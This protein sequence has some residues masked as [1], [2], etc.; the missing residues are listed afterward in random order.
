MDNKTSPQSEKLDST[1]DD[2]QKHENIS[3][4]NQPDE[5]K[6]KRD[7]RKIIVVTM[8]GL[9]LVLGMVLFQLNKNP[10]PLVPK[11]PIK[12]ETSSNPEV[13]LSWTTYTNAKHQYSIEYPA[14][15]DKTESPSGD[16][17]SFKPQN[18]LNSQDSTNDITVYVGQKTMTENEVTFEEYV[19]VAAIQEIQN[20]NK[21]A[22]IEPV[23]LS[24]GSVGYKTTWMV[25]SIVNNGSGESESAPITYFEVPG[26]PSVLLRVNSGFDTDQ[27]IYDHMIESVLINTPSEILIPNI[28]PDATQNEETKLENE[29]KEQILA[30]SESDG[31]SLKVSVSEVSG[32]YAKGMASDDGGGGL[33]FAA[34]V[35]GS[36][37]LVWDGNGII[38]CS[39]LTGYPN[40][41]ASMISE[42]YD[43][44]TDQLIKRK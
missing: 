9:A 29:I 6:S 43:Q 24:S 14:S 34:K 37:K 18:S 32:D 19:K 26:R 12:E 21:L 10:V 20:Y 38:F 11:T 41:P 31:S 16:G 15:W 30:E 7:K 22:S 36:W 1:H 4:T 8:L 25:Q 44:K 28:S 13:P 39:D 33:W 23:A 27:A 2:I 40:F 3:S 42:C 35:N 5:N 17:V